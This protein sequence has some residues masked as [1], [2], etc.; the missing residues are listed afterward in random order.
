MVAAVKEVRTP[1]RAV[2]LVAAAV[3]A[4]AASGVGAAPRTDPGTARLQ[5]ALDHVV[6]LQRAGGVLLVRT[7]A[8]TLVLTSGYADR[9]TKTPIRATDR[10]RVASLTKTFVAT[11][12]LQLVGEG[13]LSL[14][15]TV[16]RW[17]PGAV[18]G[19]DRI[20]VRQLLNH[21]SGLFDYLLDPRTIAPFLKQRF[22]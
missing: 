17:L 11:V 20:L 4:A 2:M 21:T 7:G 8:K 10:F 18:P 15:D 3:A 5:R 12:V 19:G 6:A 16:E 22:D 9:T 13:K 1:R 14:D